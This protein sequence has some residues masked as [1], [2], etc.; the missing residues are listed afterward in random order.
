MGVEVTLEEEPGLGNWG[1]GARLIS[2]SREG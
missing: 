2:E 1:L